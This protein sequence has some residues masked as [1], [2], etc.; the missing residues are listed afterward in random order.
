M[1]VLVWSGIVQGFSTPPLMLLVLLLTN[2]RNVVGVHV[3]STGM[4]WLAGM[5]VAAIFAATVGL[6]VSFWM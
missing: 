2:D 3:N 6:L 5:T 1:K 4:N